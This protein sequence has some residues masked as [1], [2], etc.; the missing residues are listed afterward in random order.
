MTPSE[1]V[2]AL[3]TFVAIAKA[4]ESAHED[5]VLREKENNDATQDVLHIAELAP[6]VFAETNLLATLHQL[7]V[8][9]RDAKKELEVTDLFAKWAASN[10]KA[11]DVLSNQIGQMKKILARQPRD[12]YCLR[13]NVAGRKGDWITHVEPAD[14]DDDGEV[15]GQLQMQ[16]GT[17][18]EREEPE[19][20]F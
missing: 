14:T 15:T 4:A 3:S 18:Y 5:A 6:E 10:K 8:D 7:R 16:I 20:A 9:R 12:M 19:S 11:I 17:L 1:L 2:E 13:T